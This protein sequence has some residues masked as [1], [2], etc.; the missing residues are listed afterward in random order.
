[1]TRSRTSFRSAGRIGALIGVTA[2]AVLTL[3]GCIKV[4]ANVAIASDATASGTFGFELQKDAAAFL[5]I[6][7]LASFEKAMQ[8]DALTDGE[9]LETFQSCVS[10][11]SESGFVYTCSFANATFN[12]PDDLWQITK[13]GS[14]IVFTMTSEG[15]SAED[16]EMQA[17][18]GDVGMG[19]IN[20]TVEFPGPITSV[21]GEFAE[22]TSDTTAKV[23]ASMLDNLKVTITSQ[24]SGGGGF[25]GILV[26][27]IAA[28]VVVLLIVA[29]ILL[30]MRRRAGTRDTGAGAAEA[31]ATEAPATEAPATEAPATEAPATEAPAAEAPA[32]EAVATESPAADEPE[33]QA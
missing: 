7:D 3:T 24:E 23:S 9:E 22:K 12:T 20:V 2:V 33:Q 15:Q 13:D 21:E 32:A 5:E 16:A 26:V 31:P 27:A 29:V 4:D 10:S 17:M 18:L 19:D 30:V 6:T 1:M 8:E 25:A 28:G 14:N 11:E